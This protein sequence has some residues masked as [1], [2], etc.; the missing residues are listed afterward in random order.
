MSMREA[1]LA[2]DVAAP[3]RPLAGQSYPATPMRIRVGFTLDGGTDIM[4]RVVTGKLS[5]SMPQLCIVAN[6]PGASANLAAKRA[7]A[8]ASTPKET[9]VI[10][11]PDL[12]QYTKIIQAAPKGVDCP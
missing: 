1:L 12:V 4:T 11:K 3:P 5:E 2:A 10:F 9:A 7:A 8:V 6:R